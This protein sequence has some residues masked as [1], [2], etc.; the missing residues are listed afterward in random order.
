M[1]PQRLTL[2]VLALAIATWA[3]LVVL[4]G[5]DDTVPPGRERV[6]FW[7]F[8]GGEERAVV[9]DVVRRFNASQDK[10]WVEEVPVPGNNLDMK[11]FM[12]KAGGE[13]PDLLNQ[14]DQVIAQ[15]ARRGVLTP[16]REL[17]EDD[18]EYDRL[19]DWLSPSAR[20][21]GTY[22]GE[23]YAVCNALDVRCL[24][25]RKDALDG[26]PP[27]ETIA[28]FDA[29]AKRD[30]GDPS[31]IPYLPD[32]RRLWAWGVVFGG[33][34]HDE[35]TGRITANDPK[36][37]AALEWMVSYSKFH[38][39][40]DVRA[41][42]STNREVGASSMIRQGRYG[43]MMDGQWRVPQLDEAD[44]P[45]DY[46]VAPLP[47]PPGGRKNAGW[48]NGNFFLVPR[49]ATNPRG[50]M[51]FV[52]FWSGFDGHESEAAVTAASGGWVPASP[53]VVR[54]PA[55]QAFLARH[56]RFRTFVELA[57]SP[58]QFPTPAVPVQSFYYERLNRAAE[59]A[60]SLEKSPRQALDDCQRDVQ[61]RL[62]ATSGRP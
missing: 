54:E 55:F 41:F 27:P 35:A 20:R 9:Q 47:S 17:C 49:N 7:H 48:V 10:F 56:P 42:R 2:T 28:E 58:N 46:G 51:A 22:D 19:T 6:V 23:L 60:L 8:W 45:L 40:D 59:E 37:V 57:E 38:G 25:Y 14:D 24:V 11:F 18:T 12:A 32:D 39:I 3:T 33:N 50:A 26:R 62:D 13:F 34:F 53:H 29:I 52:K 4:R 44:P 30:S 31:R 61:A 21:I 15:W 5:D 43:L 16:V 1:T 36:I